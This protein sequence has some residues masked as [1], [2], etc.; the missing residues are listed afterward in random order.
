MIIARFLT[1][2]N[3]DATPGA[4]LNLYIINIFTRLES[5]L[6]EIFYEPIKLDFKD[7]MGQRYLEKQNTLKL[8]TI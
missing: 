3:L 4:S 8:K 1:G 5:F 7:L 6:I 2:L